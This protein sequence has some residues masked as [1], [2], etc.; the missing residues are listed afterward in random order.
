MDFVQTSS[1]KKI[2]K[3]EKKKKQK[4]PQTNQVMMLDRET[5]NFS[6]CFALLQDTIG[7]SWQELWNAASRGKFWLYLADVIVS[8]PQPARQAVAVDFPVE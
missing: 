5:M 1:K 2:K 8:P 4:Y 6:I 7:V 3:N